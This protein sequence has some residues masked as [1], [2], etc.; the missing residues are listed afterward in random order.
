MDGRLTQ[1]VLERDPWLMQYFEDLYCSGDVRIPTDDGDAYLLFPEHRW[2]YNKLT[3]AESQGLTHAPHGITPPRFPVFSKPIYNMRGMGAESRILRTEAEYV[4]YLRPGDM[5]MQLLEGE[6]LSSDV[7]VTD[8]QPKWWRHAVGR[9]AGGGMFDYWIVLAERRARV[10][11]Y[12]GEWIRRHLQ[13]Y[14]G[15][16]NLETIG[17][18]I[19]EVHLRF[20]DQWPDLYGAGWLSALVALYQ[21]GRW[22]YSDSDRRDGYSVALFGPHGT[23][24]RRPS[25]GALAGVLALTGVSSVQVTF[26]EGEAPETHSM[27]PGGF[28]LAIVNCWNLES[29]RRARDLLSQSFGLARRQN[30]G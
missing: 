11:E 28:R 6:H 3:I 25:A 22:E 4:R 13:G 20:S 5:W 7:A 16:M 2:V 8:G 29:G 19:I 26:N 30:G 12:C 9:S 24:Y 21:R 18:K 23:S 27:P 14:T 17:G 10:E 15:M 1:P